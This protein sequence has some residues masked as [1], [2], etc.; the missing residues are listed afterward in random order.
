[1]ALPPTRAE[2]ARALGDVRSLLV[3]RPLCHRSLARVPA[4]ALRTPGVGASRGDLAQVRPDLRGGRGIALRLDALAQAALDG[5]RI[6]RLRPLGLDLP[7]AQGQEAR[8]D[9]AGHRRG[10]LLHHAPELA[11]ILDA[12]DARQAQSSLV[13][14]GHSR[15]LLPLLHL[16]RPGPRAA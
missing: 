4:G 6:R 16:R 1:M 10:D 12:A 13:D 2:F 5:P 9:L 3:R 14:A 8:A 11:R 7:H 15:A